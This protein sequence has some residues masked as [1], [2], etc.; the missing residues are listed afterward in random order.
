[1]KNFFGV[2]K[3]WTG[4]KKFFEKNQIDTFRTQGVNHPSLQL[5]FVRGLLEK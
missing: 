2:S 3:F 5:N 1:M 4:K